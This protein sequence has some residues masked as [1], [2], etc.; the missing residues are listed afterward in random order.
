M[1]TD[2][3]TFNIEIVQISKRIAP[4]SGLRWPSPH[5]PTPSARPPPR[6]TST[7]VSGPGLHR[8]P[9]HTGET[10]GFSLPHSR[11]ETRGWSPARA[12]GAAPRWLPPRTRLPRAPVPPLAARARAGALASPCL[13]APLEGSGESGCFWARE[14]VQAGERQGT[15]T[16]ALPNCPALGLRKKVAFRRE[17]IRSR[18]GQHEWPLHVKAREQAHPV[19]GYS[20]VCEWGWW[21]DRG[22]E[23]ERGFATRHE[24][25]QCLALV[26]SASA[27]KG[28]GLLVPA[29]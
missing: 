1:K 23:E 9:P 29:P 6:L 22:R 15:V 2:L 8:L 21:G 24:A 4:K 16:E 10:A 20:V 11:A 14:G 17:P 5:F 13:P 19:T 7:G 26:G 18:G 12:P 27:G 3:S 25:S 28:S